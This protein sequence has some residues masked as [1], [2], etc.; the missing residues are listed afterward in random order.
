M[1][2]PTPKTA[3]VLAA[4]LGKRMSPYTD[5]MPKPLVPVAG[6]A[7]LDHVLD[8]LAEAGVERAVVNVHAFAELM[9]DHLESRREP[10]IVISD[11]RGLL[12]DTGGAVVKAL[13]ELGAAPFFHLNADTIWIDGVKP[14]LARLAEAFD[15]ASM[16]ALLLLAPTA[17]SVGYSGRGDFSFAA[18]GRL[19]RR[20][21][22]E[23]APFVYAGAAIFAPAFLASSPPGAFSLTLLFD[24]AAAAGRLHGLRMEGL[25]MHVGTPEAIHQAEAAIEASAR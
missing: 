9:I 4:G 25:W 11:E 21:E 13:P 12:L 2:I 14:N 15:A 24:R 19:R 5:R 16:D 17:G 1:A 22:R 23:V 3:M 10:R 20:G 6:R 18:D 7:L 8:R